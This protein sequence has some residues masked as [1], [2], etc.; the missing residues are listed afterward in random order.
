[1][2]LKHDD[3]VKKI[4]QQEMTKMLVIAALM[5]LLG[6]SVGMFVLAGN[7]GAATP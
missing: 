3:T 7:A 2:S 5:F 1:M 6:A 4:R